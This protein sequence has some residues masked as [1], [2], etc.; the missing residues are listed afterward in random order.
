MDFYTDCNYTLLDQGCK[1]ADILLLLCELLLRL[2]ELLFLR[3]IS[4]SQFLICSSRDERGII[5]VANNG[6]NILVFRVL[7]Q[8]LE[9]QL[10]QEELFGC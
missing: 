7:L 6:L 5:N 4:L 9:L 1:C 8:V 2:L 3:R 10:A